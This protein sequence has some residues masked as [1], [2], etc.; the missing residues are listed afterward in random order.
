MFLKRARTAVGWL[1]LFYF[2][3]D[4]QFNSSNLFFLLCAD[5]KVQ[6]FINLGE[7]KGL[8]EYIDYN[9]K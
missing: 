4:R 7:A 6:A 2:E 9:V 8:S 5:I 3:G 1:F